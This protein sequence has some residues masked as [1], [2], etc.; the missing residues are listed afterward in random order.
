MPLTYLLIDNVHGS[1]TFMTASLAFRVIS[2]VIVLYFPSLLFSLD[3][4]QRQY[5]IETYSE[6]DNKKSRIFKFHYVSNSSLDA[7]MPSSVK[8]VD[9]KD[10]CKPVFIFLLCFILIFG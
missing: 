6:T 10:P 2:N 7:K 3:I 4:K 1:F 9:R 8:N 5:G